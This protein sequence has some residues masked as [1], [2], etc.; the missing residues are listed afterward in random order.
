MEKKYTNSIIAIILFFTLMFQASGQNVN[1]SY[2]RLTI[3][4]NTEIVQ[5][6]IIIENITVKGNATLTVKSK[7]LMQPKSKIVIERGAKLIIDGGTLTNA[8]TGLWK[9][10]E[11]WGNC[12]QHQ[13]YTYQGAV[14]IINGGTIENAVCGISTIKMVDN[15]VPPPQDAIPDYNYTG[16]LVLVDGGIFKNNRI[17]V[18]FWPYNYTSSY[19]FF[20]NC[21]FISNDDML[22]GTDPDNFI[23]MSDI[24]G[25]HVIGGSF[26]DSHTV[27]NPDELTTGI[28]AYDARFY[29][30]TYSG[31]CLFTGL[32]YGIKAC[33]LNP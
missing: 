6:L 2:K 8:G 7:L 31:P 30:W 24:S 18:K 27:S 4:K 15:T 12:N 19:S 33:A 11:V 17:A 14:E 28:D 5:E 1:W 25:V 29:I 23:E 13:S 22:E 20:R 10:I 16:G 32:Y 26:T 21:Q 3:D 9:G